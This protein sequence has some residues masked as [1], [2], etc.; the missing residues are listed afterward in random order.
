MRKL[1]MLIMSLGLT[2]T[3][4]LI[5]CGANAPAIQPATT[6]P[7]TTPSATTPPVATQPAAAQSSP[8]PAPEQT[9]IEAA[10]S[11]YPAPASTDTGN[12]NASVPDALIQRVRSV[13]AQKLN[14]AAEGLTVQDATPQQWPDAALGCPDPAKSYTQVIVPGYKL[15]ISDGQKSYAIHTTLL[16]V[17]GE[18]MILCENGMPQDIGVEATKPT[19]DQNAQQ[20][21]DLASNDLAA[22]LKI[23]P[24][25]VSLVNIEAVE[26]N[27]SSL[28]C[29][30]PGQVYSQVVTSGY[31]MKL[32]GNGQIY[33]YHTDKNSTVMRCLPS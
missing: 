28:G 21:I 31:F 19:P 6:S 17:S 3:I 11:V 27:D 2:V 26:W 20:M 23:D 30:K 1:H 9:A 24:S 5:S 32:Q 10:P 18:P 13:L 8:Y 7:V 16:A 4:M 29:A 33:E 12:G 15:L 22:F 25:A 14:M